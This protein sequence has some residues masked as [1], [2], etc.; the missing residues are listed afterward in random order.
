MGYIPIFLD[1]TGRECVVVGGGEI[2]ARKVESLLDAGAR[3]TVVSPSLSSAME[4]IVDKRLVTHL[5]RNYQ[6]GDIDGLQYLVLGGDRAGVGPV[7]PGVLGIR[8]GSDQSALHRPRHHLDALM[9]K[10][11]AAKVA[12]GERER[13]GDHEVDFTE[14][15]RQLSGQRRR[16]ITAAAQ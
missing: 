3:V 12:A 13:W 16:W 2:A 5:A 8:K 15:G 14:C 11:R 4:T 6:R 7:G 1:V 10:G 9:G